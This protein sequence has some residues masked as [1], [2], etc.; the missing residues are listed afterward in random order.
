[1][2]KV[3]PFKATSE[4]FP[5]LQV[6]NLGDGKAEI[7]VRGI[8]GLSK[9]Y[10]EWGYE[11]AGTLLEFEAELAEIGDVSEIQL[12]VF[13]R[14]GYVD[15][16]VAMHDVLVAHPAKITG[17]VDGLVG[18]AATVLLMACESVEMPEAARWM[19]HNAAG[20][21]SGDHRDMAK[22][23]MLLRKYTTD[24]AEMYARR[25]E[26]NTDKDYATALTEV[27]EMMNDET[28]L[29]GREAVEAGF[30]ERLSS[31]AKSAGSP[32]SSGFENFRAAASADDSLT[33]VPSLPLVYNVDN[34]PADVRDLFDGFVDIPKVP[35]KP[36][37]ENNSDQTPDN[38]MSKPKTTPAPKN[39]TSETDAETT[40]GATEETSTETET[41]TESPENTAPPTDLATIV[42]TAAAAA[43]TAA[44][45]PLEE[46]ITA[47]ETDQAKLQAGVGNKGWGTKPPVKN[48]VEGDQVDP[49][50][51]PENIE[52]MSAYERMK[53]GRETMNKNL[54]DS[55]AA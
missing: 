41:E 33:E 12:N 34:I 4:R 28:W 43:V 52:N 22:A 30:V 2:P 29:N 47:L 14:G 19:I 24:I 5:W 35:E 46:K 27:I 31:A 53:H 13:S 16:A 40:E 49:H 9:I 45:K 21:A 44:M 54:A 26:S 36:N 48:A 17:R 11:T 6:L 55:S 18:S 1:M 32:S 8:I 50:A 23:S 15:D 25:I 10:R 37:A 38:S 42:A 39:E 3:I 51:E 7:N 20:G